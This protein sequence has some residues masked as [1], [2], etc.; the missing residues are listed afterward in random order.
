MCSS[1]ARSY[2]AGLPRMFQMLK[3]CRHWRSPEAIVL[4][5]SWRI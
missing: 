2:K 1:G 4:L 5:P 3:I